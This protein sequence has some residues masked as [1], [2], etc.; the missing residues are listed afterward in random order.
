M[1]TYKDFITGKIKRTRGQFNG[2]T[3]PTGLLK[4]PYA[5]FK[6]PCSTVLVPAYLLTPETKAA[7]Q[8]CSA[9]T[10]HAA[11]ALVERIDDNLTSRRAHYRTNDG[12]LLYTLDEV[13]TA[14]LTGNLKVA[15]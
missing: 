5:I 11:L 12:R 15:A 4:A 13:V 8:E 3:Q 14:I 10:Y 1:Y 9:A 2:W 7:I 6:N